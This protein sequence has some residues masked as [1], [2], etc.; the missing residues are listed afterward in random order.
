[1]SLTVTITESTATVP[2][3]LWEQIASAA[4]GPLTDGDGI[5]E[6]IMLRLKS[7]NEVRDALGGVDY[8]DVPKI[9]K[10]LKE[11][12][13]EAMV[14]RL[15]RRR[16]DEVDTQIVFENS[17]GDLEVALALTRRA[18]RFPR[19]MMP[20]EIALALESRDNASTIV[21]KRRRARN[22]LSAALKDLLAD[23]K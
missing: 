16:Y 10:Q 18:S 9:V 1:M 13:I 12:T 11:D 23:D 2:L 3:T 5:A 19:F 7:L 22:S 20:P 6:F 8:Q 21:I 14:R 4:G 17:D 15:L